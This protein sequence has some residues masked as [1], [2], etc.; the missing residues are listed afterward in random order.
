MSE[1]R[2]PEEVTAAHDKWVLPHVFEGA[3][4]AYAELASGDDAHVG[5]RPPRLSRVYFVARLTGSTSLLERTSLKR[6]SQLIGMHLACT[7]PALI[8]ASSPLDTFAYA[9]SYVSYV[10]HLLAVGT[11]SCS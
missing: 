9:P 1:Q 7:C 6:R 2:Q 5:W 8:V 3:V 10:R 4:C 11:S